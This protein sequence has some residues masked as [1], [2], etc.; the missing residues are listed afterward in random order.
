M[1]ERPKELLEEYPGARV[2]V[3]SGI[4]DIMHKGETGLDFK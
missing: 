1:T 4:P 2:V 3:V